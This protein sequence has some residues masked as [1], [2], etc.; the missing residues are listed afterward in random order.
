[1]PGVCAQDK[2]VASMRT[3]PTKPLAATP[4]SLFQPYTSDPHRCVVCER[5]EQTVYGCCCMRCHLTR[6]TILAA[7]IAVSDFKA[8]LLPVT[9]P[10][11]CAMLTWVGLTV[12][13]DCMILSQVSDLNSSSD[14]IAAALA[15]TRPASHVSPRR[16]ARRRSRRS[17]T[18]W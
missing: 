15:L 16:G 1:M 12:T 14:N 18:S 11:L 9:Y 3:H 7:A 13:L 17:S 4:L 5:T 6:T 2:V 8:T 10:Y